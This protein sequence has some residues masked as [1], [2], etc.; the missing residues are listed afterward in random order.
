ME[1]GMK[2]VTSPFAPLMITKVICVFHS[3]MKGIY[4]NSAAEHVS[5]KKKK[6]MENESGKAIKR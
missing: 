6:V 3:T 4:K 1:Q 2:S 5:K